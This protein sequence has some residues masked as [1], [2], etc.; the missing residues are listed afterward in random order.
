MSINIVQRHPYFHSLSPICLPFSLCLPGFKWMLF[1]RADYPHRQP[2]LCTQLTPFSL[3][4]FIVKKKNWAGPCWWM[5]VFILLWKWFFTSTDRIWHARKCICAFKLL[6][7]A[8]Y[9]HHVPITPSVFAA[10]SFTIQT[11]KLYTC[12][13][14]FSSHMWKATHKFEAHV[15]FRHM[16]V[17]EHSSVMLQR[18]LYTYMLFGLAKPNSRLLWV[19][20]GVRGKE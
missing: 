13:M 7:N 14:H 19:G 5:G 11:V 15:C 18:F 17:F 3:I 8:T 12:V 4:K 9:L 2:K 10:L 20:G 16:M 6:F 1:P